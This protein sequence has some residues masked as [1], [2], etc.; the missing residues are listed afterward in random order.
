MANPQQNVDQVIDDYIIHHI[1]DGHAW[2]IPF[3]PDIHLPQFL[4]LHTVMLIIA[5]LMMFLLFGVLYQRKSVIPKGTAKL[6]EPLVVFIRDE[7]AIK[8]MG[9]KEGR[10]MAPFFCTLFFYILILNIMGLIPLF[11]GATSNISVTAGLSLAV[12]TTIIVGG[13]MRNGPVG[14]WK[15]FVPSGLPVAIAPFM[16][17]LEVMSLLV[18]SAALTIRLGANMIAGHIVVLS[19]IGLLAKS[20][21]AAS[22]IFF[23]IVFMYLLKILVAFLQAY[24]FCFLSAIFMGMIFHPDH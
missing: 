9:E 12:L 20:G 15:A 2:H 23:M 16:L 1:V 17:V 10:I 13:M 7:I 18:K 5:G 4:S 24:I 11:A 6:F 14:F 8:A 3:L 19:L 21:L 22:P